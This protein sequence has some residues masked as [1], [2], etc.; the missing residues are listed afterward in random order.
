[1]TFPAPISQHHRCPESLLWPCP[2]W[3]WGP[4]G[5]RLDI[6]DYEA[7]NCTTLTMHIGAQG[8]A[9]RVEAIFCCFLESAL[10]FTHI[11]LCITIN[12]SIFICHES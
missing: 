10:E 1:M 4:T 8:L 11:S 5:R 12:I 7:V 6:I 9:E 2:A 3:V